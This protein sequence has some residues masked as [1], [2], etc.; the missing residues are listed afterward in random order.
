MNS[1]KPDPTAAT[2]WFSRLLQYMGQIAGISILLGILG[3]PLLHWYYVGTLSP[4]LGYL[5][6]TV[7]FAAS[8]ALLA[9]C[10]TWRRALDWLN[11]LDRRGYVRGLLVI[12]FIA[13]FMVLR[14]IDALPRTERAPDPWGSWVYFSK[15]A[16][17]PPGH[18]A[19]AAAVSFLLGGG[20]LATILYVS[21]LVSAASWLTYRLGSM[22]FGEAAGRLAGLGLALFPSWLLYGNFEYHLELGTLV[23]LIL[24]LFFVRPPRHHAFWYIALMGLVLGLTCLVKPIA[25]PFPLAGLVLYVATGVPWGEATKRTIVLTAFM[26][27][28]ILPWTIR[29]YVVLNHFVPISTNFGIVLHTAN[30][31]DSIGL[32]MAMPPQPGDTDEVVKDRRHVREAVEWIIS[33]PVQFLKLTAYRVAWTWGAD[34]GFINC[35]ACLY[36]KASPLAINAVRGVAQVVYLATVFLWVIGMFAYRRE[37]MGSVIGLAILCPILHLWAIHLIF[38][39]HNEHH[40]IVLPLMI[41]LTSAML[42]RHAGGGAC[43]SAQKT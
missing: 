43:E 26:L 10:R 41:I 22:A 27:L 6:V 7:G 16:M 42:V 37:I 38:Q 33:N 31:P 40:M 13:H 11:R 3:F 8:L 19:L 17:Y 21:V 18:D 29:N 23:L 35:N 32:E 1:P 15:S 30:N 9:A 4:W 39:S 24:Y 25:I 2:H 12:C 20:S 34:T 14:I 36:G 5:G 28:A